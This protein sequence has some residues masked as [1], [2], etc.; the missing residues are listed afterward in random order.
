[1]HWWDPIFGIELPNYERNLDS[2]RQEILD[3]ERLTDE[4]RIAKRITEKDAW[5]I[6]FCLL[7]AC[8]EWHLPLDRERILK[9][10]DVK[11]YNPL[12]S[13]DGEILMLAR[14]RMSML[15]Q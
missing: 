12:I 8:D 5:D 6:Y 7:H 13:S 10:I 2:A 3:S 4:D 1:V 14:L 11:K 15:S 9:K